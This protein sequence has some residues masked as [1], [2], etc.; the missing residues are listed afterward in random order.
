MNGGPRLVGLVQSVRIQGALL[1]AVS[2]VSCVPA[3][4]GGAGEPDPLRSAGTGL[5]LFATTCYGLQRARRPWY[6][7]R[8]ERLSP[9][10]PTAEPVPQGEAF[11][12][13]SRSLTAPLLLV[14]LIGLAVGYATG[15]PVGMFVAGM[16]AG[17]LLQSRWLA[18]EERRLGGRVLCLYT[19]VR[20]RADDPDGPLYRRS[21]FWIVRETP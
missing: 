15:I 2:L 14:L 7:E 16:A 12:L 13:F 4:L 17:M 1:L 6:R 19:P 18:A 8:L 5:L 21:P 9:P 20:V 11:D 10:P 3:F